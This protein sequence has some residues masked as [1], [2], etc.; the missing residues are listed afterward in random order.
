MPP[1][2]GPV[3]GS[4]GLARRVVGDVAK[5]LPAAVALTSEYVHARLLDRFGRCVLAL[6]REPAGQP[7]DRQIA[8]D[9]DFLDVEREFAPQLSAYSPT[10]Q[11]ARF[12]G[13]FALFSLSDGFGIFHQETE[14]C[15]PGVSQTGKQER[16]F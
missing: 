4:G 13:L 12:I 1:P 10:V 2:T 7:H 5:N 6:D 8:R 11:N 3:S 15:F 16:G 14:K 9:D